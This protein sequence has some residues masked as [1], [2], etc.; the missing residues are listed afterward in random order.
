MLLTLSQTN[1]SG[2]NVGQE[3]PASA[4]RIM[5]TRGK[6]RISVVHG[7]AIVVFLAFTMLAG[8]Q[9][10]SAGGKSN[11][12]PP[13]QQSSSAG[14][15]GASTLSLDFGSV[16]VASSKTLPL[17]MTNNGASQ[18]AV[19][20]VTFSGPEFTLSQPTIPVSI[21][22]GQSSTWSVVFAPTS[23]GSITASM[24]ITSN[25][26][27][28]VMTV[29]LSG[30]GAAAQ[31]G[32][33]TPNLASINFGSVQVGNNQS[34]SETVT[35]T[36]GSNV[37]ISQAKVAGTG[38]SVNGINP[39]LTLT[40][41]QSISFNVGFIPPSAGSD[42]GTLTITSDA[43]NATLNIPLAG[44]GSAAGQLAV[45]P[46]SLNLGSVAV[47]SSS[48]Q[49]AQ[50]VAS[51]ASVTVSS[52]NISNADFTVSGLS[53]PVTIPAGQGVPFTVTFTPQSTGATSGTASFSSD[54][55]NSPA[56]L[57]VSGTGAQ[58]VQHSVL[59][60]WT[61]SSSP[62][63]DGYNIYRSE[64]SGGPYSM[65]NSSLNLGTSYTDSSVADGST[66]FYVTTAVN[67]NSQESAYSNEAQ[68]VIP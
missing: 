51:G 19:S 37:T 58:P 66:Y 59:L 67:S 7:E 29:S 14:S 55:S 12:A 25:A 9:G 45:N 28:S 5:G 27:N 56:V 30:A 13:A 54:A 48:Q 64:T 41:G 20:S 16:A 53:L 33:L 36:G 23:T 35:N 21:A 39:P 38:F 62:N 63:I 43:S 47:G 26:S 50:L 68:A 61:A 4:L 22:A 42:S 65:L 8:C 60:S 10:L 52:V 1:L 2:G 44:I 49:T 31:P 17:T 32:S 11:T 15:L 40:A 34:L 3:T 24:T 6:A 46:T 57:G 18:I